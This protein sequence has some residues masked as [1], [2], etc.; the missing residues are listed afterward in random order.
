MPR[1]LKNHLE[2]ANFV[3]KFGNKNML[4]HAD[5]IVLP[6]LMSKEKRRYGGANYFL[7]RPAL[8]ELEDGAIAFVAEFVKDGRVDR[9]QI[10]REGRLVDNYAAMQSSPSA[11]VLL[12]LHNHRLVYLPKTKYA[13][14]LAALEATCR[15]LIERQRRLVIE[16]KLAEINP[17]RG[18]IGRTRR[19]LATETPPVDLHIVPLVGA[20]EVHDAIS[21]FGSIES[22]TITLIASNNELDL[23]DFFRQL[24]KENEQLGANK[25]TLVHRAPN[26]GSLVK[27]ATEAEVKAA[28]QQG[29]AQIVVKGVDKNGV[30]LTQ[31]NEKLRLRIEANFKPTTRKKTAQKLYENLMSTVTDGMV[32]AGVAVHDA[33]AKVAALWEKWQK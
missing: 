16:N 15:V 6:A 30:E 4:D 7:Y 18:G 32:K 9:E 20:R 1:T 2:F 22:L 3:C 5:D 8:I 21:Q 14:A 29:Q 26:K 23:D 28:G 11:F 33:K 25:S 19:M 31:S 27:E 12:V 17:P 10:V 24:R 13:P